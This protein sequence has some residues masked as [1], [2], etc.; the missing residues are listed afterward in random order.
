MICVLEENRTVG[1]AVNRAVVALLDEH[2]GLALFLHL[3]FDELHDIRVIDIQDDHLGR[4]PRFSA[5]LD[6][7]RESIKTLH[8][9]HWARRNSATRQGFLASTQ[10]R[11]VRS[12][13]GAPLEKHSFGAR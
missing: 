11:E 2:M 12:R 10:G 1:V 6:H 8:E 7:P 9:T 5:A 13:A 3:A 4:A